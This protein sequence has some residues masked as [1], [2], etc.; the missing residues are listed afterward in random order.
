MHRSLDS[1]LARGYEARRQRRL[2]E[3]RTLFAEAVELYQ[4]R[5]DP[6]RLAQSFIGLGRTE[7]DLLNTDAALRHYEDAVAIYRTLSEPLLLAHTVRHVGDILQN[8]A[9]LELAEPCYREALGIYRCH[10]E[11]PPLDLANTL[12]GYALLKGAQGHNQE[13]NSLWQEARTLYMEA[14][15]GAGVTESERQMARLTKQ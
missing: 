12:R 14:S 13:A 8:Q 15:V 2:D 6:P 5:N 3:A 11:T 9:K 4:R 7:R 10:P 1:P